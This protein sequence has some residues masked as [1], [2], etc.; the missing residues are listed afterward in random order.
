M[1]CGVLIAVPS[2]AAG[3]GWTR[4]R[5]DWV[6][7]PMG[8]PDIRNGRLRKVSNPSGIVLV[9]TLGACVSPVPGGGPASPRVT[10][11]LDRPGADRVRQAH[12]RSTRRP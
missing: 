3:V 8:D 5:E 11:R 6:V 1:L 10:Q 7:R 9:I 12:T 4:I 2:Q